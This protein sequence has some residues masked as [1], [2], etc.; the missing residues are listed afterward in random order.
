MSS[1][2]N[3]SLAR[4]DE[5]TRLK[6]LYSYGILDTPR[7]ARF[8]DLATTAA[9]LL[10]VPYAKIGFFDADRTWYKS[11]VGFNIEQSQ[12]SGSM[13]EVVLEN[14]HQVTFFPNI[15]A[16][17]RVKVSKALEEDPTIR[18]TICI[19]ITTADEHVLGMLCVFDIKEREFSP[20]E[21]ESLKRI[22]RQILALMEAR[23]EA[24]QLQDALRVQQSELRIKSTTD[25]ISRTL[26]NTVNTRENLHQVVDK[27][28]QSVIN[29]F[30][31]WGA[32]AWLEEEDELRPSNWVFS[33]SAPVS[34]GVLSKNIA[35]AIPLPINSEVNLDSYEATIPRID[36]VTDLNWHPNI[37]RFEN[38]GARS[39]LVIDVSGPT[40]LA[41]RLLFLL[42][43]HRSYGANAISVLESLS[44]LL[45]QVVRRARG[46]EELAYRATHDQLTG[47]LNR[48]GLEEL[49]PQTPSYVGGHISRAIFYFDV[50]KFKLIND[51][52][53]HSVGDEF[54]VEIARRLIESSRPV[55][56]VARIGGDEFIIVAQGFDDLDSLNAASQRFLENLGKPFESHG[57]IVIEPRVSIGISRWSPNEMLGN[58]ISHADVRMYTA[59]ALG[60]HQSNIDLSNP[61]TKNESTLI[62]IPELQH[63]SIQEIV[64]SHSDLPAGFFVTITPPVYFAPRVMQDAA[65]YIANQIKLSNSQ[66]PEDVMIIIECPAF[67]R[68]DRSNLEAFFDALHINHKCNKIS[69]AFDARVGNLDSANFARQLTD[70]GFVS[71]ALSNYGEGHNEIRLIQELSPSHLIISQELLI[72]ESGS[73]KTTLEV[74]VAISNA[75][76]SP[77]V[78]FEKIN[79]AY[80]S[81]LSQAESYLIIKKRD[82]G[83]E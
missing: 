3:E 44:P 43:N 28:I 38:A 40:S 60:G 23:R 50:D 27:F 83:K 47:L 81:V 67:K 49:Y 35:H 31:W 51:Q 25:R 30:G 15:Q 36:E 39:F 41:M 34:L 57:N 55:D 74:L 65:A 75:T 66:K 48:R 59:K 56:T 61:E 62:G 6:V 16:D 58:A 72:D 64:N 18:A 68:S 82:I 26:V 71:I 52:Y 24:N 80:T 4:D 33:A 46:A 2:I 42:P 1:S 69:F 78:L 76:N 13:A 11:T 73:N 45:P 5:Q 54:L 70:A 8:D 37:K 79:P 20:E 53:G 63:I 21:V 12:L 77:L 17:S 29:E 9:D 19:P 14:P 10:N 7:E 22:A 32:Q